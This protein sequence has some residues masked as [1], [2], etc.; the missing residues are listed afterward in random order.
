[1]SP[2]STFETA[3]RG[4]GRGK[5]ICAKLTLSEFHLKRQSGTITKRVAFCL[6]GPFLFLSTLVK[7]PATL[8][9][10]SIFPTVHLREQLELTTLL[11]E[12]FV[13]AKQAA[14]IEERAHLK[15]LT[16]E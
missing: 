15:R 12:V 6:L 7:G 4:F 14:L 2:S 8:F 3:R 11:R 16:K 9:K 5:T 13:G 10:S 1:M